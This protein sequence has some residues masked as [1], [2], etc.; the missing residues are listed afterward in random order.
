MA[1]L[2]FSKKLGES[3]ELK[4]S[5]LYE[6]SGLSRELDNRNYDFIAATNSIGAL[7]EHFRQADDTPLRRGAAVS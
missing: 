3:S 1:N 6:H 2:D 5:V 4:L 7:Y